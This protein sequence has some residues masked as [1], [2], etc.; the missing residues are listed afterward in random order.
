MRHVLSW[1]RGRNPGRPALTRA[2]RAA[3]VIPIAF[4]AAGA[5]TDNTQMP[6]FA[7]F[8]SFALLLF[9]D[10]PG[11]ARAR[12]LTYGLVA[13]IGAVSITLATAASMSV[14]TAVPAMALVGF[15]VLMAA[16]LGSYA[17]GATTATLLT[18]VLP[19]SIPVPWSELP[20]RLAGWGLAVAFSVPAGMLL[21]PRAAPAP[22]RVRA[23][24]ACR[25]LGALLVAE[26]R[27]DPVEGPAAE[28]TE[29][30]A[31]L[32]REF[33]ATPYRP[34]GAG[35][36]DRA[37]AVLA[38]QLDWLAGVAAEVAA[39]DVAGHPC[40][41][42]IDTVIEVA[43][44]LLDRCAVALVTP[45]SDGPIRTGLRALRAARTRA[46]AATLDRIGSALGDLP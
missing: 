25:A 29:A 11:P 3:V 46:A 41:G 32:R 20:W 35:D 34:G 24:A 40:R 5:I 38:D 12:L 15:V 28:A 43:G 10:P 45:E 1:V 27:S 8:G 22:L 7:A 18:F 4:A 31:A 39:A 14:W 19:V 9:L 36:A 23:A 33:A 42:E 16:S 2:L 26:A 6:T 44:A 13:G 21:R 17:A 37:L 30:A